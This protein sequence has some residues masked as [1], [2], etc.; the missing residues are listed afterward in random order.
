MTEA[1]LKAL[2]QAHTTRTA[3]RAS[4]PPSDDLVAMVAGTP[5]QAAR[6]RIADHL[7]TCSDCAQE[8]RLVRSLD[9]QSAAAPVA[10]PART[11][12]WA[13][14]AAAVLVLATAVGLWVSRSTDEPDPVPPDQL[15]RVDP[16]VYIPLTVRS[17]DESRRRFEAAMEQYAAGRYAEAAPALADLARST[18]TAATY[19]FLGISY[20]MLERTDDAI[21]ALQQSIDTGSAAYAE[22]AQFFLAKGLLRKGDRAGAARALEAVARAGGARAQESRELLSGLAD[23]DKPRP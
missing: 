1:E 7:I 9:T 13:W 15:A 5:S 10:R 2:Y 21:A 3:A 18:P 17:P 8:F 16:P 4:C 20:L 23:Q 22:D 14:A 19:F 6:E 12:I 11:P